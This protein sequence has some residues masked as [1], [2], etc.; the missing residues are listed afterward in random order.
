MGIKNGTPSL[1]MRSVLP[2][3]ILG[4]SLLHIA[5]L[6]KAEDTAK[7]LLEKVP[8]TER[9]QDGLSISDYVKMGNAPVSIKG[10]VEDYVNELYSYGL[11]CRILQMDGPTTG[12]PMDRRTNERTKSYAELPRRKENC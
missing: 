2:S 6:S 5:V 9:D 3:Y 7:V 1:I 12:R 11:T 8:L 10:I 4:Q